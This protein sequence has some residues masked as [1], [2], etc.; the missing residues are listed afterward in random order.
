[1]L[2]SPCQREMHEVSVAIHLPHVFQNIATRL[3]AI[4]ETGGAAL[5]STAL[6]INW[7]NF[8]LC[9]F[10]LLSSSS[11]TGK[12]LKSSAVYLIKIFTLY[13]SV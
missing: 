11:Q 7:V 5:E 2:S 9:A 13:I 3:K 10:C 8:P 4:P 12:A 6:S 1:M